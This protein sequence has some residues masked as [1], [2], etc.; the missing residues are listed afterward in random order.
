M[1]KK[2]PKEQLTLAELEKLTA[3]INAIKDTLSEQ[4]AAAGGRELKHIHNEEEMNEKMPFVKKMLDHAFEH[5]ELVTPEFLEKFWGD[6]AGFLYLKD[7]HEN[8]KKL[9]EIVKEMYPEIAGIPGK[10]EGT[11]NTN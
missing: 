1:D 6:Y 2:T 3:E 11:T 8:A 10:T 7:I 4:A 5:Q 9:Y